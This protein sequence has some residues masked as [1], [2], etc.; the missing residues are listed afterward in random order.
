[1]CGNGVSDSKM[2]DQQAALEAS[3]SLAFA[4]SEGANLIHDMGYL[5][6]GRSGSLAQLVLCDEVIGWLAHA[7]CGVEINDET[8]ALELIDRKGPNGNFLDDPHT[9]KAQ[10]HSILE[11]YAQTIPA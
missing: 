2:V 1:M 6:A 3:L 9:V 7:V 4:T 10:V 5:E 11:R 8:F